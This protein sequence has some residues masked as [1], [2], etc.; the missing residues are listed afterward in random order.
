MKYRITGIGAMIIMIFA[1]FFANTIYGEKP[2]NRI[3]QH[4]TARQHNEGC[5]CDGSEFCTHL[6]L[7]LI[8]TGGAEIPGAPITDENGRELGFTTTD[9]GESMI[10]AK[11][12]VMSSDDQNHHPSDKPDLKSDVMIRV[13]GNSSRYFDKKSYL[14]RLIDEKGDYENEE[15]MGMAPHYEWALHGPFLDKSLIRNYMWYN[16]AGEFMGYAPN[17]RFCEVILNGEYQGVYVMVETITNGDDCRIDISEPVDGLNDTGYVLRLDRGSTTPIK[18]IITFSNYSFRNMQRYDIQYPRSGDLTEEMADAIAQDFSDFEKSLY[19]YDYDTDDY[20]Y[21]HD[22]NVEP[23]VDY[24]IINEFLVNYD[25]GWLSTYIY[26]DIG[27][28]YEMVVWDFNS[29]CENYTEVLTKPQHFDMQYTV[30]YYMFMKDEYFVNH[31]IERYR[32]LRESYLNEEY[33]YNYIDETVEY[34]GPAIERNFEVWG[35]TFDEYLPLKPER[36]NPENHEE[37][38]EQIK[39]FIHERGEW[40]DENIEILLQYSHESKNKKFNH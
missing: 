15:M 35:Y 14:L 1:V 32:E 17:V 25:A 22:I 11:I 30:L 36:R 34:L 40:M 8:D 13:R 21:Y 10:N 18:N 9:E 5:D 2:T 28:K 12:S 27:G 16:I 24:F 31:I 33:L 19:S 37:A 6:P 20:G 7:V 23:F 38:I 26:K 4:L 29:A 3:H 39:N